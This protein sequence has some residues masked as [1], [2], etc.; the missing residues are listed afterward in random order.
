M[1]VCIDPRD[2]KIPLLLDKVVQ[3][4]RSTE[5]SLALTHKV[6]RIERRINC[7]PTSVLVLVKTLDLEQNGGFLEKWSVFFPS[8]ST[9]TDPLLTDSGCPR[10]PV[11]YTLRVCRY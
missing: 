5:N 9:R 8:F 1:V 7:D 6:D 11:A 4:A 3:V 10:R 2:S